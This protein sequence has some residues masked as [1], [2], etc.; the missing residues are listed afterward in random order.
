[1]A[2]IPKIMAKRGVITK[3]KKIPQIK[4]AMANPLVLALDELDIG[5][6][7]VGTALAEGTLFPC[8][9]E[10]ASLISAS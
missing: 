4:D 1:M 10:I 7:E 5:L 3:K 2:I 6:E 8:A 9:L